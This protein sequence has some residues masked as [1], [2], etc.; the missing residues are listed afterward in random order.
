V[1]KIQK[2]NCLAV[3]FIF[4]PHLNPPGLAALFL[5]NAVGFIFGPH[6]NETSFSRSVTKIKA[7][8]TYP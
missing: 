2:A 5:K 8:C 4:G 7:C 1:L 6:L 3:G